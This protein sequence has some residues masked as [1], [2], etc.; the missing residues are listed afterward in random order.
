[1][2]ISRA[3]MGT[4][5]STGEAAGNECY[6]DGGICS[7]VWNLLDFPLNFCLS[8]FLSPDLWSMW[9]GMAKTCP[10]LRKATRCTPDWWSSCWTRTVN[11]KRWASFHM[12]NAGEAGE[13]G[14]QAGSN[15]SFSQS[16]SP[17]VAPDAISGPHWDQD[18]QILSDAMEVLSLG[19]LWQLCV[20]LC[21]WFTNLSRKHPGK[22]WNN[23]KSVKFGLHPYSSKYW[24]YGSDH[25][26]LSRPHNLVP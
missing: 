18:G 14:Q 1:M 22:T 8:L 4:N 13:H 19:K 6:T 10:S 16:F 11:G 2:E 5:A 21:I 7:F 12:L 25:T 23:L 3:C 17:W 24:L 26:R 9:R 20:V 15:S